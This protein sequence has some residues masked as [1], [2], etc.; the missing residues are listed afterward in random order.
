[1]PRLSLK[2]PESDHQDVC[3]CPSNTSL[4]GKSMIHKSSNL[5]G[6]DSLPLRGL[7]AVQ[8]LAGVGDED[9][10]RVAPRAEGSY[11][12]RRDAARA[13]VVLCKGVEV[14]A[15]LLEGHAQELSRGTQALVGLRFLVAS[16][17][18]SVFGTFFFCLCCSVDSSSSKTKTKEKRR[19]KKSTMRENHAETKFSENAK[20]QKTHLFFRKNACSERAGA[21]ARAQLHLQVAD[22]K[23]QAALLAHDPD[24]PGFDV[25]LALAAGQSLQSLNL[26]AVS[27]PKADVLQVQLALQERSA[28]SQLCHLSCTSDPHRFVSLSMHRFSKSSQAAHLFPSQSRRS[29]EALGPYRSCWAPRPHAACGHF[30]ASPRKASGALRAL[31]ALGGG[32]ARTEPGDRGR[33]GNANRI[34]FSALAATRARRRSA[35]PYATPPKKQVFKTQAVFLQ[36]L[37]FLQ[38]P[39][40]RGDASKNVSHQ[41]QST[42]YFCKVRRPSKTLAS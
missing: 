23:D 25:G 17:M 42:P 10:G 15:D 3:K 11:L 2:S 22:V 36:G 21:A 30:W 33:P 37:M 24:L 29:A 5:R 12:H 8:G 41:V 9:H 20:T 27:V 28:L 35:R 13:P 6:R 19:R 18:G 31:R 32:R 39:R 38:D 7:E 34:L 40:T 14:S 26:V 1:M 16:L 4:S